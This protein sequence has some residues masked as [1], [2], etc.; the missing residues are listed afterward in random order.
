MTK[1]SFTLDG[2]VFATMM[3][4]QAED[5]LR[6]RGELQPGQRVTPSPFH[7]DTVGSGELWVGDDG[8]PLRQEVSLKFPEQVD[9]STSAIITVDFFTFGSGSGSSWWIDGRDSWLPW[10][11]L[12]LLCVVVL[13]GAVWLVDR[14]GL[15][16]RPIAALAALAVF[17]PVAAG[18]GPP[19]SAASRPTA[20]DVAR[21]DI[22]DYAAM[23]R[24]LMA[25]PHTSLL[26][27]TSLANSLATIPPPANPASDDGTDTDTDG[28]TDFIELRIG[29][30]VDVEDTDGDEISDLV[31]VDGFEMGGQWWYPDPLAVDSNGDGI[32]DTLEFDVTGDGTPDDLDG[33][34]IP[35]VYDDDNDG[36]GVPDGDDL[37]PFATLD[38]Q[39]GREVPFE[40]AVDGADG[41]GAQSFDASLPLFVDVQLRPASQDHLQFALNPIDWPSDSEGQLRDVNDSSEDVK[42]VPMLEINL[43]DPSHVLP[44]ADVLDAFLVSVVAADPTSG[45]RNVY[46]PLQLVIDDDTGARVAFSGRVP[47]LSQQ[48][49]G[50]AHAVRL[51]WAVQMTNDQPCDPTADDAPAGCQASG[52]VY[53]V[54]QVVHRYYDD[55]TLTGLSVTQEHGAETALIYQDP[56]VDSDV[57]DQTPLWAL[58][59]VLSERFLNSVEVAADDFEHEIDIENIADLFDYS[60]TPGSVAYNLP[61]VF[62]V[63]RDSASDLDEAIRHLGQE[64]IPEVLSSK[65]GGLWTGAD[66]VRPL[67]M[68]ADT[69]RS[70]GCRPR[71]S[72]SGRPNGRFSCWCTHGVRFRS[73]DHAGAGRHDGWRQVDELLRRRGWGAGVV[74]V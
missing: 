60:R 52:Y 28:L 18:E 55:W 4:E 46:V 43:P 36:D 15:P 26:G 22:A 32:S 63:E 72:C 74:G 54:A 44:D 38:T 23:Q 48:V 25:D 67:L 14:R 70:R 66:S 56:T 17:V 53:D 50:P 62:A 10:S 40:F 42:L 68:S 47:Y 19:V 9:T 49:W 3:A 45:S 57:A 24:E 71:C 8:L 12:A 33:D 61:D 39:W 6:A 2:S 65:F 30:A 59:W 51:V 5:L 35:D 27:D 58:S 16:R 13:A 1:Y 21:P 29:T 20:A 34:G 64:A 7:R 31:E 11:G 69:S 73:G 41:F 37:S